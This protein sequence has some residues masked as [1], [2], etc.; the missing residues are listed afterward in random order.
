MNFN[1]EIFEKN[2]VDFGAMISEEFLN[3]FAVAHHKLNNSIYHITQHISNFGLNLDIKLDVNNPIAFNLS[4]IDENRFVKIWK[5]HL[6]IKGAKKDVEPPFTPPNLKI[7]VSNVCFTFIV[8]KEDGTIDF[9][10]EF[11]WDIVGTCAVVLDFIENENILRLEPIKLEFSKHETELLAIVQKK[12]ATLKDSKKAAFSNQLREKM[13]VNDPEKLVLY[14]LNQVLAT[15]I[16]NFVQ[17]FKLPKAFELM[18]GI[19]IEPGFLSIEDRALSVGCKVGNNL[20]ASPEAVVSQ[21]NIFLSDF[22]EKINEEFYDF[23][24]EKLKKWKIEESPSY[25]WLNTKLEDLKRSKTKKVAIKRIANENYPENIIIFT[26]DEISDS[27]ANKYFNFYKSED[28]E[29]TLIPAVLKVKCGWSVKL[30]NADTEIMEHGLK[31]SMNAKLHAYAGVGAPNPD[32]KHWGEWVWLNLGVSIWPDPELGVIAN[33]LFKTDGV[34]MNGKTTT[35]CIK[36]N[37]DGVPSWANA[38]VA[39]ITG[40]LTTPLFAVINLIIS[41]FD[42]KIINYPPDGFPGTAFVI[43]P[44][45]WRLNQEPVKKGSYLVFSADT[46]FE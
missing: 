15:Q 46:Y 27:I 6:M 42:F 24:E 13:A 21:L 9:E 30:S 5:S 19:T 44:E 11:N 14:L 29:T 43:K 1:P 41:N 4:P 16:T 28:Y 31:L 33:P 39:W 23:D 32:P 7:S 36:A 45:N 37:I 20:S 12:F 25:K 8:H 35:T 18:D 34:F 3:R 38:A 26:N 17:Q 2:K 10:T 22:K 40:L